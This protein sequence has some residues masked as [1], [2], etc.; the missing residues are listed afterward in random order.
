MSRFCPDTRSALRDGFELFSSPF[1][2][3][4]GSFAEPRWMARC[5][6]F[7]RPCPSLAA[8]GAKGPGKPTGP[9][10][11]VVLTASQLLQINI[12]RTIC[13]AGRNKPQGEFGH[14]C[15]NPIGKDFASNSAFTYR[16]WRGIS[17]GAASYDLGCFRG[18]GANRR[19]GT[20]PRPARIP[21]RPTGSPA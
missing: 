19:D 7:L 14:G 8:P 3:H 1:L 18:R 17:Y 20:P 6:A 15:T 4:P 13:V 9:R 10:P 16:R 12:R 5:T 11:S 2:A 21:P